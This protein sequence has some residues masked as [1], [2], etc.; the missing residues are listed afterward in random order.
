MDGREP[1]GVAYV[2]ANQEVPAR[3]A[4]FSKWYQEVH[5]V[6][7]VKLGILANPLMFHNAKAVLAPGEDRFLAMYELYRADIAEAMEEFSKGSG[8]LRQDFD[9]QKATRSA[10]RGIYRVRKR[11][12]TEDAQKQSRSLLAVRIDCPEPARAEDLSQWLAEVAVPEV[13]GLGLYH[14]GTVNESTGAQQALEAPSGLRFLAL[15]ESAGADAESLA[16]EVAR[17]APQAM[18]PDYARV[19][20][21]G[22]FERQ[23]AG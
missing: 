16:A 12:F 13:L 11:L 6:D 9:R 8:H 19:I 4:A 20:E 18:A 14:T 21:V 3:E 23:G 15:Y 17:R 7:V 10:T 1:L 5:F 2:T 22:A